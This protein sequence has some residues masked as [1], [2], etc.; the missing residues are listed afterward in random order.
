MLPEITAKVGPPR[1]IAV[2]FPLGYPFGRPNDPPFQRRILRT[3]LT[4]C[5][6]SDVPL[7]DSDDLGITSRNA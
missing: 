5:Y 4:A 3:L 6:R 1:A 7:L 2:P